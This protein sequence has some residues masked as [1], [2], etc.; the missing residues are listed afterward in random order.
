MRT[1]I[2]DNRILFGPLKESEINMVNSV[3]EFSGAGVS[4]ISAKEGIDIFVSLPHSHDTVQKI[5]NWYLCNHTL[6][7]R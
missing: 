4:A 5:N 1:V 6:F 3:P 2:R 7:N